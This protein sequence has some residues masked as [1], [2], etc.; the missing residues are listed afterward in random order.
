MTERHCKVCGG[1]HDLAEPWPTSCMAHYGAREAAQSVFPLPSIWADIAPYR[2][3][4]GTGEITS[5][6]QRREDMK[7][8][9]CREVDPSEKP[10]FGRPVRP[11]GHHKMN[12]A[13][14][15]AATEALERKR[16]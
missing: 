15:K 2:S 16:G 9:N 1:W 6:S 12:P 8:G 10:D 14:L 4:L 5:R 3:P 7:R 13:Q 11:K